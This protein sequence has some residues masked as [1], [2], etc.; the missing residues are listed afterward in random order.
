M[1]KSSGFKLIENNM[2]LLME[3]GDCPNIELPTSGG[4]C[5][6]KELNK[7]NGWKLQYNYLT[8]L[9]RILDKNNIRKAWGSPAVMEE[10]FKRLTRPEFLEPGDVVGVVRK[11]ALNMYEHYCVYIGEG[12]V[13]HYSGN[14]ADFNGEVIVQVDTLRNFLKTDDDYFVLFFDK[15]FSSPRKIQVRTSFNFNDIE[16]EN[17]LLLGSKR[18]WK[19]YS[20]KE[21]VER[22]LSRVG[23]RKYNLVTN[24]C[25]H[26]AVWCKTGVQESFQVK[27]VVNTL[28]DI[29]QI[30]DAI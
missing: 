27:R 23:E 10:K 26:F 28:C 2:P 25:E 4:G 7:K 30:G 18:D 11:R 6:W 21:T 1:G 24:N 20:P 17:R 3:L 22:A 14:N 16:Y 12:K 13:V 19:I 5:L 29:R 15:T 8:G 9:S